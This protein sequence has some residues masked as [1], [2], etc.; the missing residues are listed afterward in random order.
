MWGIDERGNFRKGNEEKKY[1]GEEGLGKIISVGNC[2]G[3]IQLIKERTINKPAW[4]AIA[5]K[6][7]KVGR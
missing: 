2:M 6:K 1:P 7:R 4:K 5:E 3:T